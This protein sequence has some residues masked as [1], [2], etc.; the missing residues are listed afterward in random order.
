MLYRTRGR[1]HNV[2]LRPAGAGL[3]QS[4]RPE[5]QSG[6]EHFRPVTTSEGYLLS[7]S[8]AGC[9]AMYSRAESMFTAILGAA[10][11]LYGCVMEE[12]ALMIKSQR[13]RKRVARDTA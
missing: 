10:G 6:R 11:E 8:S 1:C 4:S 2:G 13:D 3:E 7:Y 9:V 12:V 5:S